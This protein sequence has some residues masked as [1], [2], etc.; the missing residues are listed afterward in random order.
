M[1]SNRNKILDRIKSNHVLID[2]ERK[3]RP[4]RISEGE[5]EIKKRVRRV[6]EV[7]RLDRLERRRMP[8]ISENKTIQKKSKFKIGFDYYN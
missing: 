6:E 8:I 2:F 1:F 4:I 7:V 5:P 3:N